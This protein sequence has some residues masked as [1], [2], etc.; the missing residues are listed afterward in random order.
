LAVGVYEHGNPHA[1]LAKDERGVRDDH[2][3][4]AVAAI[5]LGEDL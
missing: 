1:V 3:H 2:P 4:E 5:D